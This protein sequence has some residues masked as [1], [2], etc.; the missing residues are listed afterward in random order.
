M[1]DDVINIGGVHTQKYP[2]A[3]S[4]EL[5]SCLLFFINFAN[6]IVTWWIDDA[7]PRKSKWGKGFK[8]G[9]FDDNL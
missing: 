5:V 3:G 9:I 1:R 4:Y 6:N 8:Y 2:S 7:T